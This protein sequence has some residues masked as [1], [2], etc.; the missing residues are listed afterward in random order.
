MIFFKSFIFNE[1]FVDIRNINIYTMKTFSKFTVGTLIIS[2]SLI[3]ACSTK[4]T[5][6]P[7]ESY[8]LVKVDSFQV[9][10]LTRIGIRDYSPKEKIY[11]GYSSNEDDILEISESGEI[12][13]RTHKKG[14]GPGNYG[15]MN[16]VGLSFGPN[17]ERIVELPFQVIAY[18]RDYEI[19][20]SHRIM[21]PLPIRTNSPIGTT[22]Y[23]QRNDSTLLLVGPTN[24]LSASYLIL[25]KEGKDTLQNFYQLN[26]QSG[27][28]KSIIPYE[29]TSVYKLTEDIYPGVMGKSFSIDHDKKEL[30]IIQELDNKILIYSLPELTLKTSIPISYSEFL[31]YGPVPIGTAFDDPRALNIGRLSARNQNLFK[32]GKDHLLLSYFTGVTGAEFENRNSEDKP[33]SAI[34]D[35]SEKRILIFKNK[36]QTGIELPGIKGIMITP[37]P[38][39]K[40]LVQEPENPDLEEEFTKFSIYQLKEN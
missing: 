13:K 40:L 21:S 8:S 5:S 19:L 15:N 39:N 38:D 34:Q 18:D 11:L 26:L 32:I 33:Y 22:P 25:N 23:Y 37:L 16:P 35:V 36:K 14:D 29:E 12:L 20:N 2:I 3:I 7:E 6:I 1:I 10:N 30:A 24:Y 9:N 31:S 17:D 27:A 4:N 28:V